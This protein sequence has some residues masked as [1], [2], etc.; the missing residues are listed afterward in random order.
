MTDNDDFELVRG[1]GNVFRDFN[2]PDAELEQLRSVLAARIIKALDARKMTVRRAHELTGFAAAD[3]SRVRRAN[4]GPL[5]HRP[6]DDDAR[7]AWRRGRGHRARPPDA[8]QSSPQ[9]TRSR[10][11]RTR[12][13]RTASGRPRGHLILRNMMRKMLHK[14]AEDGAVVEVSSAEVQRNFGAYRDRAD[15]SSGT[16]EPVMVLH[17]NKPSVVIVAAEE[18]ARLKRRD[19]IVM[20]AENLPEVAG[21]PHCLL[22]D[23][24]PLRISR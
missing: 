2:H 23:G 16:P 3:F 24:S 12:F 18:Y 17:Y 10:R 1:S 11:R 13:A 15:G 5:H 20:A 7:R 6:N 21:G 8:A 9:C 22:R 14:I 19:K 4:L